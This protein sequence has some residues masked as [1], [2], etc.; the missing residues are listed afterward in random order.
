[1]MGKHDVSHVVNKHG[2]TIGIDEGV[3]LPL[4]CLLPR[5]KDEPR[6]SSSRPTLC[7]V[8]RSQLF[9]MV[10]PMGQKDNEAVAEN[11][12]TQAEDTVQEIPFLVEQIGPIR[13]RDL[14]SIHSR[15]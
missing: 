14:S 11:A 6:T 15:I 8:G 5:Y 2:T 3:A 9:S 12:K 4:R 13:N 1:V 7:S 10:G